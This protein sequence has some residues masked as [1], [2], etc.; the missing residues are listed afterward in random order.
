MAQSN[1]LLAWGWPSTRRGRE[2]RGRAG[3]RTGK[4]GP[5]KIRPRYKR[6]QIKKE[7]RAGT[8]DKGGDGK[9]QMVVKGKRALTAAES[10]SHAY[11]S[12]VTN[13][14]P[15]RGEEKERKCTSTRAESPHRTFPPDFLLR[16]EES[17]CFVG[18]N[19]AALG[20]FTFRFAAVVL[21]CLCYGRKE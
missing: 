3:R 11:C 12:D 2:R 13:G 9:G 18:A 5:P 20:R 1:Q 15:A 6:E 10:R 8:E 16:F 21:C 19:S 7:G 17:S 4:D 14:R